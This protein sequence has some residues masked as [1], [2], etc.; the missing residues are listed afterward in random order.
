MSTAINESEPLLTQEDPN[1]ARIT[2][3]KPI[4]EEQ[5]KFAKQ[6]VN[7]N[8]PLLDTPPWRVLPIL[9]FPQKICA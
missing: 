6:L 2:D 7:D 4:N 1:K 9:C 8:H 5:I 3:F